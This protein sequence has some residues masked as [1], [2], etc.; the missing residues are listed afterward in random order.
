MLDIDRLGDRVRVR[1][2]GPL[3]LVAE[4]TPAGL[5]ALEL[6]PDERVWA[7]LKASEVAVEPVEEPV[8]DR[9]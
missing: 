2:H 3:E 8:R 6:G 7:S 5:A 9:T 4:L 1:L